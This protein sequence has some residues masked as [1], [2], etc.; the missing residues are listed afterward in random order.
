ME[1]FWDECSE[2]E[3]KEVEEIENKIAELNELYQNNAISHRKYSYR[4]TRLRKKVD[5]VWEKYDTN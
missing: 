5:E 2:E 4:R 3:H 1:K